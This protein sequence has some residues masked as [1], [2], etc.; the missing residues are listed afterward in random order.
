MIKLN[1]E[2]K[3]IL[4]QG[5]QI[6]EMTETV[7]WKEVFMPYFESKI[8]NAWVD[9]RVFKDD[10][11]YAYAMKTAWAMA[12]ASDEIIEFVEKAISE[13]IAMSEK[14]KGKTD[15]LRESMS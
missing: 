4:L 10:Q 3:K 9:P 5:S 15:K 6:R 14:Q 11:E 2:E 7:G 13:G 1:E 8:R 12:K